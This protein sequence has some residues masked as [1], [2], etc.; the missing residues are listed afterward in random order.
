LHQN[1]HIKQGEVV[2]QRSINEAMLYAGWDVLGSSIGGGSHDY[3]DFSSS[4][5]TPPEVFAIGRVGNDFEGNKGI[6]V[7]LS[8]FWNKAKKQLTSTTGELTWDYNNRIVEVRAP[9][10][11]AIIGFAQGKSFELP[12]VSVS[13]IKTPFISLLFTPL[14]NEDLKNSKHILITAMAREK[15]TGSEFNEDWTQLKTIGGAPLLMEP[16]QAQINFKGSLPQEINALDVYGVATGK[17][18]NFDK[19]GN[20]QIDGTFQ[21]TYY[22]MIR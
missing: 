20:F 8:S 12:G 4:V 17:K 21:S 9:K 2:A 13:D 10:T 3:K 11:Q 16:V 18:V 7:D 15:Q 22:E 1:P 6:E 19:K 14:D 5:A